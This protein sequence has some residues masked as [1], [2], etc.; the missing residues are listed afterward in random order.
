M[1]ETVMS[2][3]LSFVFLYLM[4]IVIFFWTPK[5]EIFETRNYVNQLPYERNRDDTREFIM[6]TFPN[7]IKYVVVNN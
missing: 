2:G 5:P 6:D 4:I 7:G 3:V 1:N